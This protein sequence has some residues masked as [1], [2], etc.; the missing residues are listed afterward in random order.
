MCGP[1]QVPNPTLLRGLKVLDLAQL[2]GLG[3]SI[4]ILLKKFLLTPLREA[5]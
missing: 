5:A 2:L 4:D 1:G 3:L